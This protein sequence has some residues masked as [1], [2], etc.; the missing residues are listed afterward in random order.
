MRPNINK[1]FIIQPGSSSIFSACTAVYTNYIVACSGDTINIGSDLNLNG[2]ITGDTIYSNEFYSGTTNLSNIFSQTDFYVTGGTI[3]SNN[4]LTL[5]RNDTLSAITI[6]L[7]QLIDDTNTFITGVT[8][9]NNVLTLTDNSGNSFN[10]LID[11][12]SGLTVN[13]NI[14][15][16]TYYGDGSQLTGINNFYVT[17][18]T[19]NPNNILSLDRN[20]TLS[21]ITIDLNQ[22]I[23]DTNTFITGTSFNNNNLALTDNNGN[24][25]NTSIDNFSGLTVNGPISA[26]TYYGDGSNLSGIK[27]LENANQTIP[28][29]TNRTVTLPADSTLAFGNLIKMFGADLITQ[30]LPSVYPSDADIPEGHISYKLDNGKVLG[31]YRVDSSTYLDVKFGVDL[32]VYNGTDT[33]PLTQRE[34]F[35]LEEFLEAVDDNINGET[36]FRINP[37]LLAQFNSPDLTDVSG[38]FRIALAENHL[39]I[40]NIEGL[41]E[42]KTLEEIFADATQ[43]VSNSIFHIVDNKLELLVPTD[44]IIVGDALQRGRASTISDALGALSIET[45]IRFKVGIDGKVAIDLPPGEIIRGNANGEGVAEKLIQGNN[46]VLVTDESGV[47][48]EVDLIRFLDLLTATGITANGVLN[49]LDL[50]GTARGVL[51]SW[52]ITDI[53]IENTTANQVHINIGTIPGGNDVV[54]NFQVSANFFGN[55]IPVLKSVFSKTVEQALHISS[56]DWNSA[57]LVIKISVKKIY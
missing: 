44:E 52:K 48:Q 28:A 3:N 50:D 26:T 43:E 29:A 41:A 57:E 14:S 22:L 35:R 16:T 55:E 33:S 21:A 15:G 38:V 36:I 30:I 40:G 12:F 9:S 53:V 54:S 13:G 39:K 45:G 47:E 5:D 2:S 19:I 23:D 8:F 51:G 6:D 37:S 27:T 56:S 10:T 4:I 31:R 34:N 24:V 32:K 20:D 7:N 18:G 46:K 1:T 49:T 25:Y 42:D 17:G 11:D